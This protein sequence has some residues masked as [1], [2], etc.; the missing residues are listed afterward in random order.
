M[1]GKKDKFAVLNDATTKEVIKDAALTETKK[2]AAS[3]EEKVKFLVTAFPGAVKKA[4]E[5]NKKKTG[6]SFV[7][8]VKRATVK[9]AREEG[10]YHE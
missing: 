5:E 7:S 9:L 3:D 8:F 10:I 6:E 2:A 4:I 1:L